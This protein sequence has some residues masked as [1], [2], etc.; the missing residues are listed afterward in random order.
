MKKMSLKEKIS[1]GFGDF[2]NGF[3]FDLGQAYLLK[4]YTDVCGIA[5]VAAGGIF[6]FTKLF[7]AFM[8]PIAGTVIDSRK[9][10]GKYGRFRPVMFIS[11]I[12]LGILTV[13]TFITP[14]TSIHGR[15]IY[16]YVTYMLWG[17]MYS[18]TNVPYGSLGSVVTQD[19]QERSQ[20]A[21]F[22]QAGSLGSLLITGVVF[23]PIATSVGNT[24]VGFAVAATI[25]SIIGILSFFITFKNTREVVEVKRSTEKV[26]ARQLAN[27]VFSNKPLLTVILMTIFSISAYN[28]KT[29]M[30]VYFCQYYL[31]NV[32]YMIIIN[33]FSIGS[34]IVAI[35]FIPQ[36]V[37][38]LGKKRASV[39]GF[40]MSFI[41]DGLNFI[42]PV[43]LV[44]FTLLMAIS[45]VGISIPNGI[46]WAFVSDV[47]DYGHWH[48]GERREGITYAAFNFS[49]KIAQSIA[50]ALSGFG[51]G[52]IGYVPNVRQ[53]AQTLLGI[54][55]LLM[56]YP[57]I[58]L[59]IAAIVIG[60]LYGLSDK[61][62]EEIVADLQNGK[63]EFTQI[64]Q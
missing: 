64:Q 9:K 30:M 24:R 15:L 56:L 63:T 61:K 34:S 11:S 23:M 39:L 58:A 44:S 35:I 19:V 57:A 25:M 51:L 41:A 55:G 21:T 37:K 3:M 4:F 29:A 45:F 50:G 53:T 54:K 60:I 17:L 16:G 52:L 47:I 62:F 12:F 36:L 43:H 40:A 18:F 1:Y 33:F 14:N 31:G 22:R 49:R 28:I 2:G 38:L 26:T 20:L 59:V 42:L 8:D 13:L 6:L 32:K 7:D 27:A 48:T 5:S 46:T 10:V